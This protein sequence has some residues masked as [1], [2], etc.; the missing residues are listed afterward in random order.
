MNMYVPFYVGEGQVK[1]PR[2]QTN[3]TKNPQKGV[4]RSASADI[5]SWNVVIFLYFSF[6][7]RS[8]T[9]SYMII[10]NSA[11]VYSVIQNVYKNIR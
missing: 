8:K 5:I 11:L 4:D 3:Q 2:G 7:E 10:T 1:E 6:F 9:E